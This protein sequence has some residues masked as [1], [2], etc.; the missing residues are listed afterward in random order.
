MQDLKT[1]ALHESFLGKVV[2]NVLHQSEENMRYGIQGLRHRKEAQGIH[3]MCCVAFLG[4]QLYG[5]PR[6]QPVQ[7][8]GA[9]QMTPREICL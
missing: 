4:C 3:R 2:K 6:E 1:F 7:T 5:R 8:G 9:E